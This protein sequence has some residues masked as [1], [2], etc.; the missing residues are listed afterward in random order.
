MLYL[1]MIAVFLTVSL[2]NFKIFFIKI[3]VIYL[4]SSSHP[5]RHKCLKSVAYGY[6]RWLIFFVCVAMQ[7]GHAD[8][9]THTVT[10]IPSLNDW[11]HIPL[12]GL[13]S[14]VVMVTI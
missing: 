13:K 11:V 12:G 2:N 3:S 7:R 4:L 14:R 10:V 1:R 6:R 9:I 8:I 5:L